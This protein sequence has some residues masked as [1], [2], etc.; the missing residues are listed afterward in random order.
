[1]RHAGS[2]LG[3]VAHL[4]RWSSE[5]QNYVEQVHVHLKMGGGMAVHPGMIP[6]GP[7]WAGSPP[8]GLSYEVG[9]ERRMVYK[10]TMRVRQYMCEH[11]ADRTVVP[12]WRQSGQLCQCPWATRTDVGGRNCGTARYYKWRNGIV[13]DNHV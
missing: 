6:G 1:M 12:D 11:V 10:N 13:P 5:S 9:G 4:R 3:E 7:P 2:V 8:L